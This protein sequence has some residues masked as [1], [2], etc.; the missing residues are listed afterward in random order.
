MTYF[1]LIFFVFLLFIGLF[2]SQNNIFSPSGLTSVIWIF[3]LISYVW[4]GKDQYNLSMNLHLCLFFWVSGICAGSLFFQSATYHDP[5]LDNPSKTIR[6]IYLI[7]SILFLPKLFEFAVIAIVNGNT[8]Y[9]PLDLRLAAL[10]KGSGY[11]EP[12]GGFFVLIWQVSFILELLCYEKRKKWRLIVATICFM[13]FGIITMAKIILLNIF[14]SGCVILYFKKVI[15][16]KHISIG[17]V[18]LA[19][20]FVVLQMVRMSQQITDIDDSIITMYVIGNLTAFDSLEP[21]SAEHWGENT[22]RIVYATLYKLNISDIEPVDALLKWVEKPIM[23]NTYTAMYPFYVDFGHAGIII[24]SIVIGSFLGWLFK[25]SLM[26]SKF[27][28]AF[29]AI[30]LNV[31]VMQY[32]ADLL[33][34]NLT[35]NIKLFIVLAIPFVFTKHNLLVVKNKLNRGL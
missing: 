24:F 15:R 30:T 28:I 7:A 19:L 16:M 27:Y 18:I 14:V 26:G 22:F 8:G 29:Y 2:C 12:F 17:L 1:L 31:I 10:G 9:I 4:L 13:L 20:S 32:A 3:V 23:T 11:D 6:D 35:S 34:T 5:K 21:F 33:F 25:K